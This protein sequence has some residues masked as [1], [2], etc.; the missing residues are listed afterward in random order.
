M[1]VVVVVLVVVAAVVV[2]VAVDV[3][4]AGA[5]VAGVV[6]TRSGQYPMNRRC[7]H[8]AVAAVAAAAVVVAVAFAVVVVAVA[9]A[10]AGVAVA[11]GLVVVALVLAAV[12][13][14]DAGVVVVAGLV[15]GYLEFVGAC[16]GAAVGRQQSQGPWG[17][18]T[19][20][21]PAARY[22]FPRLP[23]SPWPQRKA[24]RLGVLPSPI[25]TPGTV[26]RL[27]G[28]RGER[29]WAG[30]DGQHQAA[31]I[32]YRVPMWGESQND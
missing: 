28:V 15:G 31:N 24:V 2:A 7:T 29:T 6:D 22:Q 27:R 20:P 26:R 13:V 1:V 18:K 21:G 5:A 16:C 14:G 25:Q 23:G 12:V 10:V 30:K 11:V 32:R 3:A 9:V 19:R 4:V 8:V 17:L